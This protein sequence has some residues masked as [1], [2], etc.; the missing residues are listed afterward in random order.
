MTQM[1]DTSNQDYELQA[2]IDRLR[3]EVEELTVKNSDLE[4]ALLTAVEHGDIVEAEL[5]DANQRLQAE[6]AERK[7]AQATLQDILET[8]SRDKADLEIILSTTAEHGDFMEYQLYTQAVSAMRQNQELLQAISEATSALIILA[9][10]STGLVTYANAI[11]R[12]RLGLVVRPDHNQHLISLFAYTANYYQ[13]QTMLAMQGSV[14]NY[15]TEMQQTDGLTF[16]VS[17]SINPLTLNDQ[18]MILVTAHDIS[19]RKRIEVALNQSREALRYQAQKLEERVAERTKALQQAEEKYRNIFENAA[20]GIFQ[21]TPEGRFLSVNPAMARMCGYDSPD[22]FIAAITNAGQQLYV[23]VDRRDELIAY[24]RRFDEVSGFESQIYRRDRSIIWVSENVHSVRDENGTLLYY[25]GSMRDITELKTTEEELRQQRLMSERLLLNVLPQSISQRLKR[26]EKTIVDNFTE[27]TVLFADIVG[28]TELSSDI[29]P[30]D[31]LDLLNEIFSTFDGL[32][33][34][35]KVEKIKT[36]GDAYM[37]VGGVPIPKAD[38]VA[39][40][41]DLAIDMINSVQHFK[42]RQGKAIALRIGIHTGPVVAGVIGTRKFTYDL[43]GDTVNVAS[44][45]ESQGEASRIQV[46][47]AVYD[48]LHKRY[49]LEERGQI[50]VKGKGVMTTYWLLG[51]NVR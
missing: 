30:T 8:V 16:W 14:Q 47:Q 43:W 10:Q 15:E 51:R 44:R 1:S 32:V 19:D 46:T 48:R 27:A 2:E 22:V 33:D 45:M 9:K 13:V 29:S 21:I 39:S 5:Y 37:V 28:F 7:L 38:H 4:N 24:L 49:K 41:A 3:R 26:G 35:H 25:E 42:T 50:D 20:E 17:V 36:I 23:Q 12:Q 31:L 40:I 11:A 34:R 6:I 18:A